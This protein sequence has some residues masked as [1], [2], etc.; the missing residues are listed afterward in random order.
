MEVGGQ[1]DAPAALP[2]AP[3]EQE[4]GRVPEQ[5]WTQW[6]KSKVPAPVEDGSLA[7]QSMAIGNN[8]SN[9]EMRR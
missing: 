7:S 8:E 3:S 1:L 5:V 4:A 2:Q 9:F 6:R